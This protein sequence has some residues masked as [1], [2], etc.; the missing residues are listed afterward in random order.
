MPSPI[1]RPQSPLDL[2]PS[3]HGCSASGYLDTLRDTP[4]G[5]SR[6]DRLHRR[7]RGLCEECGRPLVLRQFDVTAAV[8]TCR[9][10]YSTVAEPRSSL[11]KRAREQRE[12]AGLR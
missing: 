12:L 2:R 11:Y 4:P 10:G 5:N 8:W 6:D 1:R 3:H 7:S 9:C